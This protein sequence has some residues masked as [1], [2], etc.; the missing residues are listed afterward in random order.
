MKKVLLLAI[1]AILVCAPVVAQAVG[2]YTKDAYGYYVFDMGKLKPLASGVPQFFC[3]PVA[4]KGVVDA[5]GNKVV[6]AATGCQKME[7]DWTNSDFMWRKTD[8]YFVQSV[9][10]EKIHS[11]RKGAC[12]LIWAND[13][14]RQ[15][16]KEK[17]TSSINT[18]WPLLYETEGTKWVLSIVYQTNPAKPNPDGRSVRVHYER[19]VWTVD[20]KAADF[21][22]FRARLAFFSKMPAGQCELF[23]IPPAEVAKILGL[24]D[25]KGCKEF[26]TYDAGI[27]ALLATSPTD[28]LYQQALQKAADK[29]AQLESLLDADSCIDPCTAANG[30]P[31]PGAVGIINSDQVPAGSVLLTDFYYAANA[32]GLLRD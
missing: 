15:Q 18:C 2:S 22:E 29:A 20:W 28:P 9:T 19:Y 30:Q 10:L 7:Y 6:D 16:G 14:I 25:A 3:I 17:A 8:A 21:S 31:I 32:A 11:M 5:S 1:I 26:N 4:L 12:S 13:Y 23:A 27:T 24:L